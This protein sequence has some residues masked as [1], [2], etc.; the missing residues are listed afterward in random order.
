[1]NDFLYGAVDGFEF[2]DH[3]SG[4]VRTRAGGAA[5][6]ASPDLALA[7]DV[8]LRE[9]QVGT[10]TVDRFRSDLGGHFGFNVRLDETVDKALVVNG[11]VRVHARGTDGSATD[12]PFYT[13]LIDRLRQDEPVLSDAEILELL[14][15]YAGRAKSGLRRRLAEV[16]PY[17]AGPSAD[18]PLPLN[19]GHDLS[20]LTIKPGLRSANDIAIVGGGGYLF[21][22]RGTN[23]LID[24]YV[25]QPDDP[26]VQATANAWFEIFRA[27]RERLAEKG[28]RYLQ[29][30]IPEKSS[31][32]PD[33]YPLAIRHPTSLLAEV[34]RRIG[35]DAALSEAYVP[36]LEALRHHRDGPSAFM[37]LD[38]H[39]GVRGTKATFE[40]MLERMGYPTR[41]ELD[42]PVRILRASDLGAAF[43]GM[44]MHEIL[45]L[46]APAHFAEAEAKLVQNEDYVPPSGQHIGSR[47]VWRNEGSVLPIRVV[48]FA[49]SFFERGTM[50][51]TLSWW[52]ARW[53]RE[54]HFVWSPDVD[55]DYVDR[56]RPDWV[57]CQTIERFLPA[58]PKT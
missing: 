37:K 30:I 18:L 5:S 55:A 43:T 41:I 15:R 38:T 48:A 34:E 46:P 1:M 8:F 10:A 51:M 24:Q 52:A 45:E 22:Y 33:L 26:E 53:F 50:A 17:V 6:D 39:M 16:I 11:A 54:F 9:R 21:V 29:I 7:V 56:V 31:L 23:D 58:L 32:H 44:A 20:A 3:L 13:G 4:W 14:H 49:N 57:I 28:V 35:E 25:K 12:L 27:R 36:C 47:C 19:K 40:A 42:L 2:G